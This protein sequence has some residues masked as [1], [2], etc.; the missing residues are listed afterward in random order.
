M[1]KTMRFIGDNLKFIRKLRGY[2]ATQ[3]AEAVH[4]SQSLV[5]R[6][7]KSEVNPQFQQLEDISATLKIPKQYFYF[8]HDGIEEDSKQNQAVFFR[9]KATTPKVIMNSV[10]NQA[11]LYAQVEHMISSRFNL[12]YFKLAE[13]I[14]NPKKNDVFE[15]T[16]FDEI[17]EMVLQVKKYLSIGSGPISNVTKLVEKLGIRIVLDDFGVHG[18]DAF[19]MNIDG[20]YYIAVNNDGRSSVRIR[21]DILH[22]LGH[23]IMHSK[24]AK[25]VINDT[26][27][28]KRIEQEANQFANTFLI[29]EYE[30]GFELLSGVNINN[31]K[32]IKKKWKISMQAI[33]FRSYNSKYISKS[34]YISLMQELSRNGWR[35]KEPYDDIIP[36]EIPSYI[37][38]AL[39]YKK[40]SLDDFLTDFRSRGLIFKNSWFGQ[41]HMEDSSEQFKMKLYG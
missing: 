9:K 41:E 23:I 13:M 1:D 39:Q 40:S 6:W 27:I 38:A 29:S 4:V 24:F 25:N 26:E 36:V 14:K 19:T 30:L 31:I 2:S 3:L 20:R 10:K 22:E 12:P 35:K 17:D 28:H 21:F 16:D 34:R 37:R 8:I 7:E 32:E 18:V 33:L 15:L 5:S 11:I